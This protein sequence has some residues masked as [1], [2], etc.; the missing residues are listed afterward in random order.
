[1]RCVRMKDRNKRRT[2]NTPGPLACGTGI[3]NKLR[4]VTDLVRM[5]HQ[6]DGGL[7]VIAAEVVL[8]EL[9][10]Q[11]G[12][13]ELFV[14]QDGDR[15]A[16]PIHVDDEPTRRVKVSLSASSRLLR[17]ASL[18]SEPV[19]LREETRHQLDSASTQDARTVAADESGAELRARANALARMR[20]KWCNADLMPGGLDDP[21]LGRYAIRETVAQHLFASPLEAASVCESRAVLAEDRT[22]AS[23]GAHLKGIVQPDRGSWP[24]SKGLPWSDAE[25]DALFEMRHRNCMTD[26]GIAEAIDLDS[27]QRITQVIGPKDAHK[28]RDG[29]SY[30]K[31]VRWRPSSALLNRC[32]IDAGIALIKATK[33]V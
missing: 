13:L 8:D 1:M 9:Q 32:G 11:A 25:R 3:H 16:K 19:D 30:P 24:H 5:V 18:S 14:R 27:P 29:S 2:A 31:G 28:I 12:E 17:G 33:T 6:R 7:W 22:C 4:L 26:K 23:G 15:Y 10:R 20:T 21:Q